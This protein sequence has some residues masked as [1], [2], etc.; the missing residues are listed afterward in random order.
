[1][2]ETTNKVID[3]L[4]ISKALQEAGF[5]NPQ[6]EAISQLVGDIISKM[7]FDP[8]VERA[9]I[10]TKVA[11]LKIDLDKKLTDN[12][13]DLEKALASFVHQDQLDARIQDS[14]EK[15]KSEF[16]NIRKEMQNY[17]YKVI[18]SLGTLMTT[19]IGLVV[20]YFEFRKNF[21]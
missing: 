5:D 21:H 3:T 6:A 20:T 15:N 11:D 2:L 4:S 7:N 13:S 19:L 10:E 18:L 8:D 1:M 16:D 12:H 9:N 17:F 14:D